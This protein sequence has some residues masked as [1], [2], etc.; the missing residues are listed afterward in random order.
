VGFD[1]A[2]VVGAIK[3]CVDVP[4]RISAYMVAPNS[5]TRMRAAKRCL[6]LIEEPF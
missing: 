4:V 2:V 5:T 6:D 1:T 3:F